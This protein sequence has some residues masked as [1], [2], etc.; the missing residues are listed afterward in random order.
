MNEKTQMQYIVELRSLTSTKVHVIDIFL[1]NTH[2]LLRVT[3]MTFAFYGFSVD[4]KRTENGKKSNGE[5]AFY[6]VAH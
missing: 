1:N 6:H 4:K 5:L 2:Q 3:H